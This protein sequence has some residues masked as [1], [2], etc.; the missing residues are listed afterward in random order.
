MAVATSS[1]EDL[2]LTEHKADLTGV[3][4]G[5]RVHSVL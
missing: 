4:D 5:Q 1:G 3:K 2:K